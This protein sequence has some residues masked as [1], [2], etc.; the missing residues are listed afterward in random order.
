M[1]LLSRVL[2]IYAYDGQ[3]SGDQRAAGLRRG[4]LSKEEEKRRTPKKEVFRKKKKKR[5]RIMGPLRK[6]K[7]ISLLYFHKVNTSS[8]HIPA[9]CCSEWLQLCAAKC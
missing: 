5:R 1:E 9:R 7:L 6:A 3:H 2:L 8:N 4:N